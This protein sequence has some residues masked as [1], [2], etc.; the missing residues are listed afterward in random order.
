MNKEG[1]KENLLLSWKEI[2]AYLD[3]NV[4]TCLRWEK[5]H[6]LPVHRVDEKSRATVFAYKEELDDWLV[7]ITKDKSVRQEFFF[8]KFIINK[9]YLVITSYSLQNR[10]YS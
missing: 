3:C 1:K 8:R 2:A 7:Q 4:R 10:D 9:D 6:G 5:K